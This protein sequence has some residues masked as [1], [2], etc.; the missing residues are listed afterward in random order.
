VNPR[1]TLFASVIFALLA[2]S[3]TAQSH[4]RSNAVT[5]IPQVSICEALAQPKRFNWKLAEI[6]GTYSATVEGAWISDTDCKDLL[7]EIVPP[8]QRGIDK[9]Y[10]EVIR[11]VAKEYGIADVVRDKGW[12]DFDYASNQLYTGL[13]YR[14]SDGTMTRGKYDYVR[15]DLTGVLVV[16][17]NFRVNHGFGNGWGHLGMSRFLLILRSVSNVAPHP[18]MCPS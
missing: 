10:D 8:F 13:S 7:G 17:R 5:T 3:Q 11:R 2:H 15:A 16:K 14:L 18:C 4:A 12:K 9:T 1:G 6:H